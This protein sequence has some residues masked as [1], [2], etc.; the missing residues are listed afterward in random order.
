MPL[1]VEYSLTLHNF[2]DKQFPFPRS[3]TQLTEVVMKPSELQQ[4]TQAEALPPLSQSRQCDMACEALYRFKHVRRETIAESEPA[5]RGIEIH[6]ILAAYIDHLVRVGRALD[7]EV[8]DQFMRTASCEAREVLEKFRDN[9]AFDPDKILATELH[10]ALDEDFLPIEGSMSVEGNPNAETKRIPAYE[11]TLDLVILNSLTEA[12]IED[13]KSYYQ[14]IAADTFQSKFYPML[15]MSLNPSL[16]RVKFNLEFVRYGTSRTVEYTRADLPWLRELAQ[17]ERVRQREL[18]KRNGSRTAKASPGRHC[19]WCP[20]LLNSCPVAKTNP[21]RRM[22]PERRLRFA[23]WLQQAE[24]HNTSVL[25]DLVTERGPIRYRDENQ[26][27]YVA[28]FEAVSKK[29]Y[30]YTKVT[31]VLAEWVKAHPEDQELMEG[32]SASGLSS[33]LKAKKR[34]KLAEDLAALATVRVDS[35][36]KVGRVDRSEAG[37]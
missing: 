10:I 26:N 31:S 13:W 37:K 36:L 14:V 32:L 9:H 35:Q 2:P 1:W 4:C 19:T 16:E 18:H 12:E 15:L 5:A 33:R 7:L 6:R 23:L 34:T 25:K 21:Y 20:L 17:S 30:P 24:R 8:F 28:A 29:S 3:K 22:T 27:E 11:G